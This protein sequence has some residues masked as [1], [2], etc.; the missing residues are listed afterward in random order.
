MPALAGDQGKNMAD[1]LSVS[2]PI[3]IKDNGAARV[4]FE[5]MEFISYVAPEGTEKNAE[6]Y[7]RLYRQCY[8]ASSGHNVTQ[9]LKSDY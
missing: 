1:S 3:E 6:Y 2:G 5:L 7:L 8:K 4:A 9:I